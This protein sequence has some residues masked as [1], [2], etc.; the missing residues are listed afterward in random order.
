MKE[1]IEIN[2]NEDSLIQNQED[3][4][5]QNSSSDKIDEKKQEQ[6]QNKLEIIDLN[7][8]N[9]NAQTI[10]EQYED[11]KDEIIFSEPFIEFNIKLKSVDNYEW[12][13]YRKANEIQPNFED[14][15]SELDKKNINPKADIRSML[16]QISNWGNDLIPINIGTIKYYY[17]EILSICKKYLIF[18]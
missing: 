10:L 14:I 1:I 9:T 2:T 7:I 12:K 5:Y 8:K 6:D 4:D 13:V 11:Y 16:T 17:L 15:I 3:P 18:I